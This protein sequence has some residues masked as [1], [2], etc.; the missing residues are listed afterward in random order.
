M[1]MQHTDDIMPLLLSR[2]VEIITGYKLA[3]IQEDK[4]IIEGVKA[5]DRKEIPA[6]KVVLSMGVRSENRLY[7]EIKDVLKNVYIVGDA[8]KAGRIADATRSAA[9]VAQEIK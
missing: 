4:I 5:K 6:D 3:E 8:V 7:N 2:G 9:K 1:W